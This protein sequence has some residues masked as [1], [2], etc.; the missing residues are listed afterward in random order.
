MTLPA[1]KV[2]ALANISAD[3]YMIQKREAEARNKRL[4]EL[5]REAKLQVGSLFSMKLADEIN[6][7]LREVDK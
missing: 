5:L 1:D 4:V 3:D 7:L 2:L 6:E